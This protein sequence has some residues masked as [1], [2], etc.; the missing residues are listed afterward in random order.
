[1]FHF[2]TFTGGIEIEHLSWNGLTMTLNKL[3]NKVVTTNRNICTIFPVSNLYWFKIIKEWWPEAVAQPE[4]LQASKMESVAKIVDGWKQIDG[5][6]LSTLYFSGGSRYASEGIYKE[7]NDF[8][9][10]IICF[11]YKIV[12]F[13][14]RKWSWYRR[15]FN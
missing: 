8:F 4:P 10:A 11:K 7:N 2:P 3:N 14:V 9:A 5:W 1:M 13:S 6:K 15:D 12:I